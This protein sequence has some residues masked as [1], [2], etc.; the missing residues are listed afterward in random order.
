MYILYFNHGYID[1]LWQANAGDPYPIMLGLEYVK[2]YMFIQL[3]FFLK[4]ILSLISEKSYI[5]MF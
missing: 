3:I 1:I 5:N 2:E 4:T